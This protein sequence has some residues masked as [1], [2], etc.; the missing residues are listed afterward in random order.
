MK[1]LEKIFNDI[2]G[3]LISI[4][5]DPQ[6][7][8]YVLKVALPKNWIYKSTNFIKCDMESELEDGCIINIIPNDSTCVIDDQIQFLNK[9]IENNNKIIELEKEMMDKLNER[10]KELEKDIEETYKNIE[11]FKTNAFETDTTET[12]ENKE[13]L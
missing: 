11:N 12:K 7:G 4:E 9:I 6:N 3:Y 2:T 10:K 8:Y 5:R 1:T 13:N